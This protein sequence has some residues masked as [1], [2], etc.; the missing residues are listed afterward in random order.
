MTNY[1]LAICEI[2]DRPQ[3]NYCPD[4]GA[5]LKEGEVYGRKALAC[6]RDFFHIRILLR[7]HKGDSEDEC[8]GM[9][10]L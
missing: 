8:E 10:V 4:C 3:F 6:S 2:H 1:R 5:S 7:P 9:R